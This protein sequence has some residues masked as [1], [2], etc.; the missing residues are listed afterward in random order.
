MITLPPNN[1]WTQ[2][3][4]SDKE[5]SIWYSKSLNFDEAG[6]LKLSPRAIKITD[7]AANGDFGVPVAIGKFSDGEFQVGTNSD[8]NF[9]VDIDTATLDATENNGTNEPTMTINS[10]AKFWQ[11]RWYASA[12]QTLLYKTA[13]GASNASWTQAA[14][15]LTANVR[16]YLEVFANRNTMCVSNG[17]TIKQ[18]NTSHSDSATTNLTIPSD[19]EVVGMAYN[20]S[21][22]GVITRL[23]DTSTSQTKEA[24]FFLWDGS[25]SSAQIGIGVGSDACIG[26]CPYKSSHLVLNR[27]GQ[28]LYFNGGGF[29]ILATFPF[30]F[31]DNAWNTLRTDYPAGD[32]MVADGDVVYINIGLALNDFGRKLNKV[33]PNCPSG[34]WCFDPKIGLYHRWSPSIS[35][36][37]RVTVSSGGTNTTTDVITAA[38]GTLP[39]TGNP[40]RYIRTDGTGITGLTLY[41][42][43][44]I[45]K[46]SSTTFKLATS[47]A[48]AIAGIA[49]DLTAADS[50]TSYFHMYDLVD[51]GN[52]YH[53][54]SGAIALFGNTS[55]M[56]RD[57][58][59]GGDYLTTSLTDNDT[60][61]MTVP[62]LE[63][64]GYLVSPKI[65]PN[66]ITEN[67]QRLFVK[68]APLASG[69]EI[70]IKQRTRD[71]AGL[72]ST[73]PNSASTDEVIWTGSNECYTTT[74]LSAAKTFLDAG[75]N[76]EI[77]FIAG[78]G[79]GQSVA[80]T[81]INNSGSTYALILEE[82]VIGAAPALKSYFIVQNWKSVGRITSDNTEYQ[83]IPLEESS[84]WLQLKI[85]LIGVDVKIEEMKFISA[86]AEQQ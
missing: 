38:S 77:E 27:A 6:Y 56:Y 64:R 66:K 23:G 17:N 22:M 7:E 35:Q 58:I 10:H 24:M 60:L 8:A 84:K 34:V 55:N 2:P 75:G 47:K 11:G 73:S 26:S 33:L 44:Y 42:D 21:R 57:I 52:T 54:D 74:D 61:C 39:A 12:N 46:V 19:F 71:I 81:E 15:G 65:F 80:I 3:N 18:F 85:E 72:P 31:T 48:N 14:S 40:V 30:F 37:Y 86:S 9:N 49:I 41:S 70:R 53:L 16:H 62:F 68:F 51:Y 63:N 79:G 82:D 76:L 78:A 29:D 43:Y 59:F 4:T 83:S 45:I 32:F 36:L 69:D 20:N 5:G 1:K 67:N 28:L 50:S 25:T 13:N